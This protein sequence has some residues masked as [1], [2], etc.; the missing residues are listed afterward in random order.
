MREWERERERKGVREWESERVTEREREREIEIEIEIEIEG[1]RECE[2]EN[3]AGN[4]ILR[5]SFAGWEWPSTDPLCSTPSAR[6]HH[7]RALGVEALDC[8]TAVT[9]IVTWGH[10][11][12]LEWS[13]SGFGLFLD[14]PTWI[15][16][17]SWTS[18]HTCQ[19]R[20][21]KV[22]MFADE[23][24][25][26]QPSLFSAATWQ[27]VNE[28]SPAAPEVRWCAGTGLQARSCLSGANVLKP[29]ILRNVFFLLFHVYFY[30]SNHIIQLSVLGCGLFFSIRG[31]K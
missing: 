29:R 12:H 14:S 18:S 19:S 6:G 3:K 30:F 10:P 26:C 28:G 27:A 31:S 11:D 22:A 25:P 1:V 9:E 13:A 17:T 16:K 21:F 8:S 5:A 24:F 20:K 15:S 23:T 7:S 2:S 4:V